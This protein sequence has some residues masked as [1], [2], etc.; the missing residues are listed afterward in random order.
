M[1]G[2]LLEGFWDDIIDMTYNWV[3]SATAILLSQGW[4]G[5]TLLSVHCMAL[6]GLG[7]EGF[8]DLQLVL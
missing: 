7:A 8:Y 2:V 1:S 3:F 5:F 4:G 6:V